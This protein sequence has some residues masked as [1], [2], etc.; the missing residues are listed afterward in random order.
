MSKEKGLACRE[1]SRVGRRSFLRAGAVASLGL[2]PKAA[3]GGRAEP[4]GD[5][6]PRFL[7]Q[8]GKRGKAPGEFDVPIA[9]AV[10]PDD[11][12]QLLVTD[13][14]NARLQRFATDGKLVA[15]HEVGPNPSGLAVGRS[16]VLYVSHFGFDG[17]PDRI[18]V[19]DREG[20]LL[21]EWG[22]S[23][24]GTASST[25]P[26]GSPSAPRGTSTSPTRQTAGSRSSTP[27]A[28]SSLSTVF[29]KRC[30]KTCRREVSRTNPIR[31]FDG[32][33]PPLSPGIRPGYD[34]V[35]TEDY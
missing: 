18:T 19:H 27:T 33:K 2:I 34:Q 13:F 17:H 3:N 29:P 9:V 30:S 32:M 1:S 25:C 5:T 7:R 16:G 11:E 31:S 12:Q 28:S 4:T 35:V 6:Q 15:I 10:T 14:R 8:W 23:A 24:M 26:A 22:R 21:R 20:K